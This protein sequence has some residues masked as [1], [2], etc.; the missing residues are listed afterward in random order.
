VAAA[1]RPRR[2]G[3]AVIGVERGF[4]LEDRDGTIT[5]LPELWSDPSVR[6]NEGGCDPDGRFYC[7]TMA[8]D[9]TA[10]AGS[11]FRLDPAGNVEC[12]LGGVTISNGLDWSPDGGTVYYNDTPTA[13]IAMF[14]YSRDDGLTAMRTLT[15]IDPADGHPDGLTVDSEGGIWVALYGGGAVRRY[16]PGGELD[17]VVTLGVS[18][19]TACALSPSGDLYITTSRE[20][21]ADDAE[22]IAG[23]LFRAQVG[24]AGVSAREFAG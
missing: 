23:S 21:L 5:S 20:G 11:V 19:P 17:A 15:E 10:G 22:P 13:R 14:D 18:K 4:A 24:V 6:M 3:G 8:Y 7:G 9:H 2:G 1:L 12:V 16:A